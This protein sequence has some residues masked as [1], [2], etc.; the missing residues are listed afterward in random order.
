[1]ELGGNYLKVGKTPVPQASGC[2]TRPCQ[3]STTLWAGPAYRSF[4]SGELIFLY[5]TG[6]LGQQVSRRRQEENPAQAGW[7]VALPFKGV[8]KGWLQLERLLPQPS[9]VWAYRCPPPGLGGVGL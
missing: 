7:S 2:P 1:M 4:K 6:T 9:K 5:E 8:L 3:A